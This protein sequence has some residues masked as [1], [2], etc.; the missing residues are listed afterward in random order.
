VAEVVVRSAQCEVR[1]AEPELPAAAGLLPYASG[2]GW[3][4]Y[5]ADALDLVPRLPAGCVHAIVTDPPYGQTNE[6]YD[7]GVDPSVWSAS[8]A[9]CAPN[10]ALLSLSGN[11][12]YHRLACGIEA[13]GWTV[14][15]MWAWVYRDGYLTSAFPREGFDRVAPAMDPI[16]FATRG[17]V[18]LRLSREP[19]AEWRRKRG[20]RSGYSERAGQSGASRG[21][22]RWPRSVISSD[23]VDGFEYFALSRTTPGAVQT[24]TAHPNQKPD[25]LMDWLVGKLPGELVADWFMGSGTTGVAAVRAGRRFLGADIDPHWCEVAAKRLRAA[26]AEQE[27]AE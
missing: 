8:A 27:P 26:E 25:S 22:G 6:S 4:I 2:R 21:R 19:G 7:R 12:T 18:L 5:C 9:V 13:G 15:Q 11:P 1:A 20:Q 16:C 24:R 23:G 3:V 14:R 17:K 10:A